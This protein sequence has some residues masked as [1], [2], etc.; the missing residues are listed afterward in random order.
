MGMRSQARLVARHTFPHLHQTELRRLL[1]EQIVRSNWHGYMDALRALGCFNVRP[2]LGK[3]RVPTLVVTGLEDTT[4]PPQ[5]QAALATGIAGAQQV[6]IPRGGHGLT[7]DSPDEFNR[8]LLEYLREGD[9]VP[10]PTLD[11]SHATGA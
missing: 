2:C 3:I 4:I 9:E 6:T 1:A 8:T 11:L 10:G 5:V 7:V